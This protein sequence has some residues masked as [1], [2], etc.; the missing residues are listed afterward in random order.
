[1]KHSSFSF[2]IYLNPDNKDTSSSSPAKSPPMADNG[3]KNFAS[4]TDRLLSSEVLDEK[5]EEPVRFLF[6]YEQIKSAK[7]TFLPYI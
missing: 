7:R 2:Y 6:I 5:L 3:H 4:K 1:M